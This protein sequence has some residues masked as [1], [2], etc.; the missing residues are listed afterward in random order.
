LHACA[1]RDRKVKIRKVNYYLSFFFIVAST[2]QSPTQFRSVPLGRRSTLKRA[3][4]ES[5]IY[6]MVAK[7]AKIQ[8][9]RSKEV[10][11]GG[12]SP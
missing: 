4:H 2:T 7:G 10:V 5:I 3:E 6:S 12:I 9:G 8:N 1:D 11:S